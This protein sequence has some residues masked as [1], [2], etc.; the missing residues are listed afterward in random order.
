MHCLVCRPADEPDTSPAS[1]RVEIGEFP[2]FR[3]GGLPED[4]A[5]A[6][7]AALDDAVADGSVAGVSAAVIAIGTGT[8]SGAAGV[9]AAGEEL[10]DDPR[11]PT[12]SVAKTLTA[13]TIMQ[14]VEQGRLGLDDSAVDHLPRGLGRDDLNGATIRDLLGMRSGFTDPWNLDGFGA[15]G[16]LLGL[17]AA[18]A[19]QPSTRPGEDVVYAS[20]NYYLLGVI[21]EHVTGQ[22]LP[23][24][25]RREVLTGQRL[26]GRSEVLISPA[27]DEVKVSGLRDGSNVRTDAA[28][29]ARW[30]YELYGGGVVSD[31]SLH[32]MTNFRGEFYGLGTIDFT[33]PDAEFGYEAASIGHGGQDDHHTVRLVVFPETGVVVA[34]QAVA[35]GFGAI[36][37]IVESLRKAART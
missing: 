8:W 15:S 9:D 11:L 16:D 3:D 29:L 27:F 33:H 14:L 36:H 4:V 17:V 12:A 37:A 35:L 34:V 28:T 30:G 6:M 1:A 23:V 18:I 7:Q 5:D 26:P 2:V 21:I 24:A 10:A 20:V 31:A 22:R 25:W 13:A 19:N 32:E